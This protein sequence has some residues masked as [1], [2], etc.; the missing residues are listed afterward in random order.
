[1]GFHSVTSVVIKVR[2]RAFVE[3]AASS[4][5][6]DHDG[7]RNKNSFAPDSQQRLGTYQIGGVSLC[8]MVSSSRTPEALPAFGLGMERD[9]HWKPGAP[10]I[11]AGIVALFFVIAALRTEMKDRDWYIDHCRLRLNP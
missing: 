10:S 1:M 4:A 9:S 6:L 3:T 8:C 5:F 11:T 2:Q 7:Q